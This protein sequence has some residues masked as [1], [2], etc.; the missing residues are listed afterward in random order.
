MVYVLRVCRQFSSRTRMELQF[1][2]GPAR[3][4][5]AE[6]AVNK[7]LMMNR[8]TCR[9]SWQNKFVKLVHLVIF[10]IKKFVTM[11]GHMNVKFLG[12]LTTPLNSLLLH[13]LYVIEWDG[14]VIMNC[15]YA[16]IWKEGFWLFW[17]HSSAVLW[18]DYKAAKIFSGVSSWAFCTRFYLGWTTWCTWYTGCTVWN[19]TLC[20]RPFFSKILS[21]W[22]TAGNYI[23]WWKCFLQLFRVY[24]SVLPTTCSAGWFTM[25]KLL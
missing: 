9:V 17:R 15:D 2:P 18:I 1:H 4:L 11:H 22:S 20:G 6:C 8:R 5:I 23:R 10:I 16:R 14:K 3:K 19:A 7:L 25:Q 24:W 13:G 12:Y 21:V